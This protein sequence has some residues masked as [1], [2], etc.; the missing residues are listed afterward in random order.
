MSD[1][2]IQR[3]SVEGL[4][5]TDPQTLPVLVAE[6]LRL[7]IDRVEPSCIADLFALSELGLRGAFGAELSNWA[8]RAARE[9]RDLP[10]GEA[11]TAF[12]AEVGEL[13]PAHVPAAMREALAALAAASSG[14]TLAALDAAAATWS[15]TPPTPVVLPLPKPKAV[16]AVQEATVT[17][18]TTASAAAATRTKTDTPARRLAAK[19]PAAMVDPRRGEWVREDVMARLGS[20]EYVERG[21][22]ESILVAGVKHRSPYKDLTDEEVRAELRRLERERKLKHTAERWLVR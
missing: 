11:R 7:H 6:A 1:T 5:S 12:V 2:R 13:D 16:K 3:L 21:L 20:R 22:K 15:A 14:P 18:A 4:R 8:R 17:R 19:T 9:I 10:A